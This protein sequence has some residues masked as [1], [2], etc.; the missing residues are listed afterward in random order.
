MTGIGFRYWLIKMDLAARTAAL[1][2]KCPEM[3]L[4]SFRTVGAWD[5]WE[6]TDIGRRRTP[7][8]AD[9]TSRTKGWEPWARVFG[10]AYM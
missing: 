2:A 10:S 6:I 1:G 3:G 9:K 7:I 5:D 4:G 8:N